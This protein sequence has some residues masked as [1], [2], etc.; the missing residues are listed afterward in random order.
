MTKRVGILTANILRFYRLKKTYKPIAEVNSRTYRIDDGLFIPQSDAP[1]AIMIYRMDSTQPLG[2]GEFLDPDM[3][4]IYID[5]MK[6]TNKKATS[7]GFNWQ[8]MFMAGA[9]VI[10]ILASV[11]YVV[12]R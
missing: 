11:F 1:N 5:S 2:Y 12:L 8:T 9:V 3:T 7:F 6:R 10:A 4:K